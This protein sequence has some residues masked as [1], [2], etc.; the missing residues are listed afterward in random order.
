MCPVERNSAETGE[1]SVV[2]RVATL[3]AAFRPQDQG[4]GVS[5]LARRTGLP[6]STVHRLAA[7]L[8]RC[9]LLERNGTGV[10]LGLR[11][12]ELG[13][14]APRRR[15]LRGAALPFMADLREATRNTIHLAVLEGTEVVYLEILPG[16]D[17]PAVPSRVGGRLPA[18]ATGVGKA[19]LAF[20]PDDI[21]TSVLSRPLRPLSHRTITGP[22][23]LRKQL[24]LIREEG[25][26]FDREESGAGIVCVASPVLRPDGRAVAAL[27]ISGRSDRMQLDRMAPAVHTAALALAR[28]MFGRPAA[29]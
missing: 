21:V 22:G 2:Q 3:L 17:G 18:H 1:S 4:L 28:R 12:F 15:G 10:Q 6:K 7:D 24:G 23:T 26:A 5:E 19:I 29:L 8:A 16:P 14:L 27:S 25:V 13:Q 9:G 20:A 11:L